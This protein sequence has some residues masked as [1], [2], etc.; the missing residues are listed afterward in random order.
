MIRNV[1]KK[2]LSHKK[3]KFVYLKAYKE[4]SDIEDAVKIVQDSS[5]DIQLTVLRKI[6][7]KGRDG[8]EP[9]EK[10]LESYWNRLLGD[11]SRFG[12][13]SSPEMGRFYIAGELA[14]IFLHEID[15]RPIGEMSTGIY[16]VLRGMGFHRSTVDIYLKDLLAGQYLLI[17]RG[18]NAQINDI[19][20]LLG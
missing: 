7:E 19:Q 6:G 10:R 13:L 4:L 5:L 14:D 1:M 8:L 20:R 2:E 3:K 17:S 18:L 15:G 12:L 11:Y 16:G 9:Q